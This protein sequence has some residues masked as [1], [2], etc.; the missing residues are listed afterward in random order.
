MARRCMLN[1]ATLP[2]IS[3]STGKRGSKP[4]NISTGRP[5]SSNTW[6]TASNDS[7]NMSGSAPGRSMSFPPAA[8][9]TSPGRIARA[10]GS[11]S[12][13]TCCRMRPRT[14]RLA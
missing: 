2:R 3:R 7:A 10:W 12:S 6:M 9:L 1:A 4:V 5:S 14:A 13:A 11:C 8:I